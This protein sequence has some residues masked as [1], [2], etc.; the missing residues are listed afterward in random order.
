[1]YEKLAFVY[2]YF[3]NWKSRLAFE[4]PFLLEQLGSLGE[5]RG[6]VR[7][8]DTAC[9]TGQHAIALAEAGFEVT[10]TDLVPQMV[11]MAKANAEA[12]G[13]RVRFRTA[14]FGAIATAFGEAEQFEVVLCLGNSLPHVQSRQELTLA[15]EDFAKALVPGGLLLLQM[16][17]F[18]MVTRTRNRWM[19]PQSVTGNGIEHLFLRFYDFEPNGMIQFNI[20][21][22]NRK[23][24]APWQIEQTATMLLP[25]L[26]EDLLGLLEHDFEQIQCFGSMKPEA[27]DAEKSGD[28]IVSA[29]RK[30]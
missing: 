22:M 16:R 20:L 9:G 11:M 8:L 18:D 29:R 25:I 27:Y 14:G 24:S 15:L 28:F 4:M 5:D 19:E 12:A 2:D 30:S 26:S 13:Q 23:G 6:G 3:V 10:G 21:S 17:N 1:M 7:V